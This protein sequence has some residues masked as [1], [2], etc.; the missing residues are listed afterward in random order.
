MTPQDLQ[1]LGSASAEL[2]AYFRRGHTLGTLLG[3]SRQSQ[4]QLYLLA[5]RLY[6]QAKYGEAG[7]IFG[8][9]GPVAQNGLGFGPRLGLRARKPL[10]AA[11]RSLQIRAAMNYWWP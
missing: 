2:M 6:G 11:L 4:E 8:R 7:H 5:H 10:S 3:V 1:A 9:C